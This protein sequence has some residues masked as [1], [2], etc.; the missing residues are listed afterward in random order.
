MRTI[1]LTLIIICLS[2]SARANQRNRYL[3]KEL[4]SVLAK[5]SI[6]GRNKEERINK[7]KEQAILTDNIE[8]RLALYNQIVENYNAYNYDSAMSYINKGAVLATRYDNAY[9]KEI[10]TLNRCLLF[11]TRGYYVYAQNILERME[12]PTD[13]KYLLFR[14]NY[15]SY[16]LYTYLE[17]Y[18]D[19]NV[20]SKVYHHKKLNF[21]VKS[22]EFV[23]KNSPMFYYLMGEY[24]NFNKHNFQ[25]LC[26]YYKKAI[27]KTGPIDRLYASCSY[28]LA[29]CYKQKGE[30][31]KYEYYLIQA[32]MSD[33][34]IPVKENVALQDVAMLI[35]K[36]NKES[37]DK[38]QYYMTISTGDALSY[39]N[40]L[41]LY[42]ISNKSPKITAAYQKQLHT[43]NRHLSIVLIIM[44]ILLIGFIVSLTF[45]YKETKLLRKQKW[46]L[47]TNNRKLVEMNQLQEKMNETL[48]QT[49]N[50][51]EDFA[52]LYV[53]LCAKYID[54]LHRY[55]NL[56]IRKIK[57]NQSKDLSTYNPFRFSEE[58]ENAFMVYFDRTFLSLYPSFVEEFNNLLKDDY[59]IKVSP[60]NLLTP[61]LRIFAL[62]RLG[63]KDVSD[64]SAL[65]FLSTRTIYNYKSETKKYASNKGT[66]D[67]DL[68]NICKIIR[69]E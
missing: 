22:L 44:T 30:I 17:D 67:A 63:V 2:A 28:A 25:L 50:K 34:I 8:R 52:K 35:Y 49:N 16:L 20:I 33:Q 40:R 51:R 68:M 6:Y 15:C 57:T 64:I 69:T 29:L 19:D 5:R 45:V 10:N 31:D 26:Y 23:Q 1:L 48:I 13:N 58:D 55:H 27:D 12:I 7:I 21:L 53:D 60:T 38:A 24:Y 59:Q 14:Y 32:A 61:E 41:R 11:C 18:S 65:L 39:K 43:Q 3:Y 47:F 54:R 37:L 36:D 66:F 62:I 42:E 56:V 46:I 4:D 9:Y